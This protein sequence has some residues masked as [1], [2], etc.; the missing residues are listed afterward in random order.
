MEKFL[1]N[2]FTKLGENNKAIYSVL[3]IAA[4]KGILRPT[5]TMMDKKAD[6]EVKKY[7]AIREGLTEV[8]A[9]GVYLGVDKAVS[10][11]AKPLTKNCPNNM[12]NVKNALS[13][14]GVC[15]SA[16]AIIPA[17]CNV[18]LKP[19]MSTI[20]KD[21]NNKKTVKNMYANTQ[22]TRSSGMKV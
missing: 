14:L 12:G 3:T 20:K 4:F 18:A 1:T 15:A 17:T 13:F 16:V 5:F 2:I 21:N 6:P 22:I 19:I 10:L 7:T 8:I 9:A 11:L